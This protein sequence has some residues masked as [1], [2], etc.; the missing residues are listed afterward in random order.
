[1]NVI[2]GLDRVVAA[3]AVLLVMFACLYAIWRFSL[4]RSGLASG[5]TA[6]H[7]D[8]ETCPHCKGP[9][10]CN[11]E[12]I[13]REKRQVDCRHCGHT[14]SPKLCPER[15]VELYVCKGCGHSW[16]QQQV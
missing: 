2:M 1:M 4:K 10:L 8:R 13:C 7:H 12:T 5:S 6:C 15:L 9:I 3:V 16:M 14:V 11:G